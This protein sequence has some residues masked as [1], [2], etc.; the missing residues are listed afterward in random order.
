MANVT[1]EYVERFPCFSS[2]TCGNTSPMCKN[3][4]IGGLQHSEDPLM[5]VVRSRVLVPEGLPG[6]S[7]G[8][9][10][11]LAVPCSLQSSA[12]P[13]GGTWSCKGQEGPGGWWDMSALC[14][15]QG[16]WFYYF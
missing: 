5:P 10:G 13:Q 15:C 1:D 12:Q 14:G 16:L 9:E 4:A 2:R 3:R 11:A 6:P 7:C 8:R